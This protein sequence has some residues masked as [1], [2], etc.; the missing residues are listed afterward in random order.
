MSTIPCAILS[1]TCWR[2][3]LSKGF[4]LP[5]SWKESPTLKDGKNQ[6][7]SLP[8][9]KKFQ[10]FSIPFKKSVQCR[11]RAERCRWRKRLPNILFFVRGQ[12]QSVTRNKNFHGLVSWSCSNV[13]NGE[14]ILF[15][16]L[17]LEWV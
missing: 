7:S 5:K 16:C 1:W 15:V 11:K 13:M 14:L 12:F 2:T 6:V 17:F 9:K 8:L 10:N 3:I 4:H